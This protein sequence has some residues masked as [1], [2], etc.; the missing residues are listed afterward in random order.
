MIPFLLLGCWCLV[1]LVGCVSLTTRAITPVV[2]KDRP[3]DSPV[4]V[5][6]VHKHHKP[7]HCQAQVAITDTV[8][9]YERQK[10]VLME[11][12]LEELLHKLFSEV[13]RYVTIETEKN[14]FE[15][16]TTIKA[17]LGVFTEDS[18]R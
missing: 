11:Y 4:L 13:R 5:E 6:H 15:G 16:Y 12:T 14:A 7:I 3:W 8:M 17:S 1:V 18:R 10:D 2:Y 9:M